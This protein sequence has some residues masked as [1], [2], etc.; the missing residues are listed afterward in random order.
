[1]RESNHGYSSWLEYAHSGVPLYLR[2]GSIRT[3]VA[4]NVAAGRRLESRTA[5]CFV[6]PRSFTSLPAM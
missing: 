4:E 5:S 6:P 2:A 1:M 3:Y